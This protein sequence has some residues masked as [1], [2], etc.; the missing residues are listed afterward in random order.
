[1][2]K[3]L[4][5]AV[6]GS[7]TSGLAL[8]AFL[9][10]DGHEVQ[11]FERFDEPQPLGAGI[12]LQPTGLAVLA[13]LGLDDKAIEMGAK[14]HNLYGED[15][16]GSV[17]FDISYR[18]LNDHVF[19]LGIHR[20]ALFFLLYDEVKRLGVPIVTSCDIVDTN[21]TSEGRFVTDANGQ[22]YGAFDL[23]VDA[24][25]M[26][27]PL[28]ETHGEIKYNRSY[29]YGA[30]WG[31]VEDEGQA[32]CTDYLRQVYAGAG[33]MIGM[34]SIGKEPVEQK[35][36][37]AFFWS[38]PVDEYSKWRQIGLK[39]GLDEWKQKVVGYWPEMA[40]FMP[41]FNH[42][43]DL[44]FSQYNDVI[45]RKWNYD[46]LVFIG[47]SA[48]CTSPQLG[49]GGNLGLVDAWTLADCIR[50]ECLKDDVQVNQAL[51]AYGKARKNHVVFYQYASR[52]LTPFFQSNSKIAAFVRNSTFGLMCKTPYIKTEM[53]RTLVGIK[54]GLFSYVNPKKWHKDY[55]INKPKH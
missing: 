5:I 50:S 48:H 20:G 38:L 23:V 51:V 6:I 36:T 19:G 16:G 34:L 24:C 54:T 25:G 7:G 42:V 15:V 17:I 43:D 37:A 9:I 3:I 53:L 31:V 8:A 22:I 27:S 49:Q 18:G 45:M 21:I 13:C 47:D 44:T 10:K 11:L 41:Q 26:R 30:I 1:M 35:Q 28:R 39:N 2:T 32:F 46:R 33:V 40:E 29:S 52:L 14:I 4:K 55:D 12:L